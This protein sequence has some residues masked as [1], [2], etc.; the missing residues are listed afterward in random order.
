MT[1]VSEKR[2]DLPWGEI[3]DETIAYAAELLGKQLRRD[4]MAGW[5]TEVNIDAIRHFAEGL[6]DRNPLWRD[7]EYGP[8]TRWGATLAPP[9][10]LYSVDGTTVAPRLAGV[11]WLYAG[12]DW[13][14]YD[15]IKRGDHFDAPAVF[16]KQDVKGGE[17]AK[18]WVLQTGH[19]KYIRR[20][21]GQL[22]GEAYGRCARTPRGEALK[23]E[24][25]Q[26]YKAREEYTYT[27]DE[28]FEIEKA[29]M[30]EGPRGADTLYAEDVNI[31]D[32]LRPI[33][34]GPL[35]STD[36]VAWYAGWSG[37][38][39]YGGAHGDAVRYRNRHQDFHIS[40]KTGA[41]ESA[42]RGHLERKT[43]E[44]VG[45]G[46][47]YDIGPQRISWGVQMLTDWM[48]DDG[49]LHT[50]SATVSRPNLLGDTTTWHGTVTAK[51]VVDGYH[52]ITIDMYADNQRGEKNSK[53]TATVLLPSK[54]DGPVVT[55]IPRNLTEGK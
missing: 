34:K 20:Q 12:T 50:L 11:Q 2:T 46:G 19:I 54:K 45:M 30:E 5:V 23:K 41:R 8:T 10:I 25:K 22:V 16:Y 49:F 37:A 31:G 47:A 52:L 21:D 44:D 43:G 33:V 14:W 32:E 15:V 3:T 6:G 42:G 27:G 1:E 38:G 4:R 40:E 51:D 55:P 36:M 28:I 9:T 13:V 48:G 53:A 26:K 24:G 35:T 17:F 7:P 39:P 29:Q 18:R